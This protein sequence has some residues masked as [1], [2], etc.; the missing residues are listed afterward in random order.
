MFSSEAWLANP[1][2]GFYNGVATQSL[3]FN[4][5]D[6]AHLSFTPSSANGQTK[7]TISAWV[8]RATLG[9]EQNIFHAGTASGN[10]GALRF[11]SN[12]TLEW[13]Y[14][15]GSWILDVNTSAVYRDTTNWYH[16]VARLD[17]TDGTA[18]IYVNG[19]IQTLQT[20]V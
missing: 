11:L 17:T 3:R 8:K 6:S 1:S 13:A 2:S 12:D 16:I 5:G 14:Y 7:C 4:D 19:S 9:S 18:D 10:R 20:S 15:N